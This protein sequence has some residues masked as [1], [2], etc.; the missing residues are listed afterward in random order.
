MV[1]CVTSFAGTEIKFDEWNI[2]YA[3]SGTQEIAGTF[4]VVLTGFPSTS[5]TEAENAI[6]EAFERFE[7]DEF[8]TADLER[9]KAKYETSFYNGISSVLGKGYQLAYYNEYFGSPDAIAVEL[10][11]VL[12]VNKSDVK[13]VYEKYVKD[14]NYV[15]TSFV[16]RGKVDLVAEGSKLFPIKE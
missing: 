2:D 16:P 5:L 1:D 13:R 3:Y 8:T 14:Q 9:L 10:Q 11:K 12:D 4:D 15:L 6:F 7:I